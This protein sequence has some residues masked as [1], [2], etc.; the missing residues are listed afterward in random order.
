MSNVCTRN[1]VALLLTSL[2]LSA[3]WI[4]VTKDETTKYGWQNIP[5]D[6]AQSANGELTIE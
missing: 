4:P 1:C 5:D 2:S 3:V 6:L